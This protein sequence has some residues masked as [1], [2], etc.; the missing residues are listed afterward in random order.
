[1]D[2]KKS[3][4]RPILLFNAQVPDASLTLCHQ[5][6]LPWPPVHP[7]LVSVAPNAKSFPGTSLLRQ[8][9]RPLQLSQ[10]PHHRPLPLHHMPWPRC[11]DQDGKSPSRNAVPASR[12]KHLSADILRARLHVKRPHDPFLGARETRRLRLRLC[13]GRHFAG[14]GDDGDGKAK[15]RG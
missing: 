14:P 10:P 6:A 9:T 11:Q 2:V 12:L 3:V 1:V 7:T 5:T 15:G 13:P 8:W 4:V